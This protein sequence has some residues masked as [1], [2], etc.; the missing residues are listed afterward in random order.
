MTK[1]GPKGATVANPEIDA[2]SAVSFA[3]DRV[4]QSPALLAK[5]LSDEDPEGVHDLR[6]WSRRMQEVLDVFYF[7]S[8]PGSVVKIRRRLRRIRRRVGG[9]RDC[10]IALG[11]V[12]VRR[13]ATRSARKRHAW[14]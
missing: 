2:A 10:D 9:W 1:T 7:E 11:L 13:R 6:V 8:P 12:R 5:V 3:E 14:D 4:R